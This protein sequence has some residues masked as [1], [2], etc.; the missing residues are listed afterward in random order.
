MKKAVSVVVVV[1]ALAASGALAEDNRDKVIPEYMAAA[2]DC[3]K[4][5]EMDFS[6]CKEMMKDGVDL[7][8][9]KYEPCKCVP[10]CIAKKRKIMTEAGDY[11]LDAFDKAIAE[12]GYEPWIEEYKRVIPVCKDSFKGKKNCDAAAAFA[13][14][15]WKNSKMLRDTVGQYMGSSEE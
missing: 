10:A 9:A 15:G 13:V 11:D 8:Q 3:V 1:A 4:D 5:Y 2:M 12:M 14:C 7:S 6:V